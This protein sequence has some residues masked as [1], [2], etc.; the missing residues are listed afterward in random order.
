VGVERGIVRGRESK[1]EAQK[2][3][4]ERESERKGGYRGR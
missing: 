4:V 3:G 1:R 2:G